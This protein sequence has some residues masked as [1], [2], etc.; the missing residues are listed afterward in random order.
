MELSEEEAGKIAEF[1]GLTE[2]E[3]LEKFVEVPENENT[4]H[5]KSHPN[6]DCIFLAD[7][8]CS[9]YPARPLQCRTFPF[10]PENLKSRYRWQITATVC[11]GINRGRLYGKAEIEDIV[12]LMK[13][14]QL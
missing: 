5:L 10:W 13:R 4:F 1:L 9:I 12:E 7:D 11:P 8:R 14:R 3:F 2:I 6:G